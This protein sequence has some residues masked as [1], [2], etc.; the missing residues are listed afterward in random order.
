[1]RML[2]KLI[3]GSAAAATV[4][5]IAAGPAL[6]DPPSGTTAKAGDIA[7]VGSDTSEALFDQ[8]SHDYNAAHATGA[9]LYSWDATN[10]VTG[11]EADPIV[12]KKGC[13]STL[14]PDGSNAGI[15]AL[16][17]N[18][19]DST[20]TNDFC[21]D[22][23]R[24]ARARQ[25]SDPACT[26]GGIC[27]VA[28]AADAITY[29]TRDAA[30]GGT[31]AP[32]SLSTAQLKNI[33]LCNTTNWSGVGGTKAPI[34]PFLPVTGSGIRTTFLTA[35][36]GGTPITP[37]SCVNSSVQQNEGTDSQLNDPDAIVPFSVAK[38]IAEVYHSAPCTKSDCT[39]NPPCA[40]SGQ[41]NKFG[42]DEAGVLTIHEINGTKPAAPWP[43]PA[44]PAPPAVN[45]NV[46]LAKTFTR[47]FQNVIY[48]VVRFSSS[49]ADHI[50]AYLEPVFSA[51][52]ASTPG[53]ACSNSKAKAD[54]QH[55]G[56]GV[57]P[58]TSAVH[59]GSVN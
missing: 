33:Y 17:Q 10:P 11:A 7:G 29:A 23:A 18:A 43:L 28:L 34:H 15:S 48:D 1:M 21:I 50:P 52:N 6:A 8:F 9:R 42:C 55:Y 31:N 12:T 19:T 58:A 13:A 30:S 25:S 32:A 47:P 20:N 3:A 35:L 39:G 22:Y 51:A 56:F 26:S 53:W 41:E 45:N 37:G 14:R 54:L 49:T 38:Y 16:Q 4:V 27:F 36:G 57:F 44:S 46:K 59:C 40:P 2:S 5:V 24:S